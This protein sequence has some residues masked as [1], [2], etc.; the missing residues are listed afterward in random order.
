MIYNV[1][2]EE[3]LLLCFL[4]NTW[5]DFLLR[6]F[7]FLSYD[8]EHAGQLN[9]CQHLGPRTKEPESF[10]YSQSLMLMILMSHETGWIHG[11]KLEKKRLASTMGK[12]Y[13]KVFISDNRKNTKFSYT[14]II[15]TQL[16]FYPVGYGYYLNF[17]IYI[18]I[19]LT[20]CWYE[21]GLSQQITSD[22]EAWKLKFWKS[23]YFWSI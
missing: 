17:I 11:T 8:G 5:I 10:T 9:Y 3:I 2:Y 21:N 1:A 12:Y 18:F 20:S 13:R 22:D 4:R 14:L 15:N 6:Y 23:W 19:A 16:F 7:H